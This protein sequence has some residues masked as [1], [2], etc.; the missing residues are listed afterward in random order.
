M[1]QLLLVALLMLPINSLAT[2]SD[3]DVCYFIGEEL[4]SAVEANLIPKRDA[5]E[6]LRRCY[7]LENLAY[8]EATQ[9][10]RSL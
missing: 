4:R 10:N 6:I 2:P 9:S 8:E 1:K 5:I 3:D 7:N